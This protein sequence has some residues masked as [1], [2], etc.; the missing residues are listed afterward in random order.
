MPGSQWRPWSHS[1]EA[2]RDG[3]YN[4]PKPVCALGRN[5]ARRDLFK[6]EAP[7]MSIFVLS[8]ARRSDQSSGPRTCRRAAEKTKRG[9]VLT[10]TNRSPL[11]GLRPTLRPLKPKKSSFWDKL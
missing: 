3:L 1:P 4:V 10:P 9:G 11:A 6:E 7:S 2:G 5:P 8:A